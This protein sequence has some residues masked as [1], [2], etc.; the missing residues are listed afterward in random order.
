MCKTGGEVAIKH[1]MARIRVPYYAMVFALF[2]YE[3]ITATQAR[4]LLA[5]YPDTDVVLAI[6]VVSAIWE[7]GVRLIMLF[8]VRADGRDLRALGWEEE[9]RQ[10][11]RSMVQINNAVSRGTL[12]L[13]AR[14]GTQRRTQSKTTCS[15][16]GK[17]STT[18]G[19]RARICLVCLLYDTM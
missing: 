15:S 4:I 17:Y 18:T 5:S 16:C 2:I 6:S 13:C 12:R 7:L 14:R 9:S 19:M 1:V 11:Y 10:L 8:K 3:L